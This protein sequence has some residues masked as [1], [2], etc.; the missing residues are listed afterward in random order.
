[1]YQEI[2]R[3][4]SR[5]ND[6]RSSRR[7]RTIVAVCV[8]GLL[9]AI[10]LP[11]A[12]IAA[13]GV[14]NTNDGLWDSNWGTPLR[15]DGDD[16]GVADGFDID[17]FW[18]NTDAAS[19]TTYYFGLNTVAAPDANAFVCFKV[20][21]NDNDVFTDNADRGLEYDQGN[22]WTT[23][24]TGDGATF[25]YLPNSDG[26]LVN[27]RYMEAKMTQ[28]GTVDW[29]ACMAG[30]HKIKAE[31]RDG[32]CPS[33]GTMRDDT[34]PGYPTAVTLTRFTASTPG[35]VNGLVLPLALVALAAGGLGLALQR[36][37]R[38]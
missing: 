4:D 13:I 21:C 16:G 5:N 38:Q 18:V 30:D 12:V 31:V 37:L 32:M 19:P 9:L 6:Q 33:N 8:V 22:D 11:G 28:G 7:S 10:G 25:E 34:E 29:T 27:T 1:M 26:E 15:V 2:R 14:I 35:D 24:Y 3:T 17:T 23:E 20:D 36:R